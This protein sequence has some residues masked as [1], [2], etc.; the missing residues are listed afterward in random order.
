[1]IPTILMAAWSGL[2]APDG[3]VPVPIPY[4]RPYVEV[5]PMPRLAPV[6]RVPERGPPRIVI[7]PA[8]KKGE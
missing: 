6:L 5:A 1:M 8:K 2:L 3:C 7:P 4:H